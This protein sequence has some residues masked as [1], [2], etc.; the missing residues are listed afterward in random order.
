[1]GKKQCLLTSEL[2]KRYAAYLREEERSPATVG[3]YV[4]DLTALQTFLGGRPL[5]KMN[6]IEW[7]QQLFC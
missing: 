5:S 2:I 7:K 6:L 4:R 1:M 3:K